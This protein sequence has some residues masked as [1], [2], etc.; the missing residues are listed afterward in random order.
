MNFTNYPLADILNVSLLSSS[1]R[2]LSFVISTVPFFILNLFT[3][4]YLVSNG[5]RS[6]LILVANL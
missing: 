4:K 1:M 3:F 6:L 2:H 5:E